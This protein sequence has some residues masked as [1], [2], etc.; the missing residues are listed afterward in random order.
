MEA[1]SGKCKKSTNRNK[2]SHSAGTTSGTPSKRK[3]LVQAEETE[4]ISVVS[5][6]NETTSSV[7][8]TT[9]NEEVITQT[10]AVPVI[11][12]V[13]EKQLPVF[14]DPNFVHSSKGTSCGKR[15]RVWKNLKQIIAGDRSFPWKPTDVTYGSIDAPP[16]FRP[17]K[18]YSDISGL[19]ASYVD[20]QTKLRYATAEEFSHVRIL[21]GDIVT[22]YLALRKA[23]T[24]VP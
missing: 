16:S 9:T 1:P 12:I 2:T 10:T 23:N 21:P 11:P 19:E 15:T 22:G 3:K 20:P 18:K 8:Q 6:E 17:G 7:R 13:P 4:E 14:K 24:P 5:F